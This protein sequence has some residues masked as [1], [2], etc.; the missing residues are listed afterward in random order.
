MV[1]MSNYKSESVLTDINESAKREKGTLSA[2]SDVI[3]NR[4]SSPRQFFER[5]YGHLETTN[6]S[7]EQSFSEQISPDLS[8]TSSSP[9]L[10]DLR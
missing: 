5:I 4:P 7:N 6:V 1:S 10:C 2:K 8:E 3:P 9:E